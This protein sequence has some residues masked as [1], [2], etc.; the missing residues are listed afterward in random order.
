MGKKK[1]NKKRKLSTASPVVLTELKG[2]D[3]EV[4]GVSLE[5][6]VCEEEIAVATETLEIL[7][8][9]PA[10]LRSNF[11]EIEGRSI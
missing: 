4:S 1:G 9:N 6:V 2:S 10:L 7:A 11:E 3:N 8:R 5:D